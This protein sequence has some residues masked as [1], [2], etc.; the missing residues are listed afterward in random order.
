MNRY[1][2]DLLRVLPDGNLE[3][4][5]N[6][7]NGHE[8]IYRNGTLLFSDS[9]DPVE[10]P[11]LVESIVAEPH[12]VLFGAGHVGKALYDLAVLQ[13]MKVTV[14][15]NRPDLLTEQRFPKASRITGEYRD[16]LSKDY[17]GFLAPYYCIFTHG[18]INDEECLLYCLKHPHTYIGMIG[19]KAK[20]AHCMDIVH[21]KGITD[22][23]M[24]KLHSPIGLG[25]NAVTPQEIAVAIMAQIISVFRSNKNAIT[26]DTEIAERAS[27]ERGVMVRITKKEG[28]SPR[29]VGSMMF[30]TE[31]GLYGTI[32]GGAIERV[33]IDRAREMLSKNE[34]LLV[35]DYSLKPVEPLQMTCGGDNS[36]MYKMVD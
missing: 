25:I 15:D 20:V 32:G 24:S 3:R 29:S 18:H 1:Y 17:D 21:E 26:I 7:E 22:D 35:E 19:S 30:V 5:T 27:K 9:D 2:S 34:R 6:I 14:F 16:L 12:L 10:N 31:S 11:D 28:S 8:A 23:M 33:A 4:R 13:D 36:V